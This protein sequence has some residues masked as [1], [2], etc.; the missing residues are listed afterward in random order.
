MRLAAVRA[1]LAAAACALALPA[2]AAAPSPEP[3]GT[4]TAT[5]QPRPA[6]PSPAESAP[7]QPASARIAALLAAGRAQ[8]CAGDTR[9][10]R[11][12]FEPGYARALHLAEQHAQARANPV[13]AKAARAL[14]EQVRQLPVRGAR[15][16][17]GRASQAR[18]LAARYYRAAIALMEPVAAAA[19]AQAGLQRDLAMAY[20]RLAEVS[21]HAKSAEAVYDQAVQLQKQ[22]LASSPKQRAW[23][24]DL[25]GMYQGLGGLQFG[26][27]GEPRAQASKIAELAIREQ[28]VEAPPKDPRWLNDLALNYDRLGD[29][30][31]TI[32]NRSQAR[33]AF[34][35]G[36]ETHQELAA[37][38]PNNTQWQRDYARNRTDSGLFE[39][40]RGKDGGALGMQLLEQGLALRSA[41]L[42]RLPADTD[43]QMEVRDSYLMLADRHGTSYGNATTLALYRTALAHM[44][45]MAA[46]YPNDPAWLYYQLEFGFLIGYEIQDVLRPRLGTV[47]APPSEQVQSVRVGTDA[48]FAEMVNTLQALV[49]LSALP[50]TA[51]LYDAAQGPRAC[52]PAL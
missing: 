11:Y 13:R 31:H 43:L 38:E 12:P 29:M 39:F 34:K 23:Q 10:L 47:E 40:S 36:M 33:D 9:L 25:A 6:T 1:G 17:E 2:G 51:A 4:V 52:P 20:W 22:A 3:S 35:A 24:H 46:A 44:Q 37:L 50:A 49:T 26:V 48:I 42:D 41:L 28:L 32:G 27:G 18:Q 30:F 14:L 7:A 8:A 5:G 15:A 19:P 16:D 21:G 45:R